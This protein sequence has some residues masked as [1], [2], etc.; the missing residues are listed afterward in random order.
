MLDRT[1]SLRILFCFFFIALSG[2]GVFSE[3]VKQPE[4]SDHLQRPLPEDQNHNGLPSELPTT[5]P[6]NAIEITVINPY[7]TAALGAEV[8]GVIENYYFEPGDLV[9]KGQVI[10]EISRKR[11][12]LAARK[13]EERLKA[14]GTALV[15]AEKDREIKEQLLSMEAG[16]LQELSRA[17]AEVEI[18][19]SKKAESQI[20]FDQAMLEL[21]AC[22]VKAPFTG[23]LA[24]RYKEAN[25]PVAPLEKLVL[26][27]DNAHVY[28]VANVPVSL[29]HLFKKHMKASFKHPSGKEF[30][31]TVER[32]EPIIDPKTDTR[33]IFGTDRQPVAGT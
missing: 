5:T 12:D 2:E 10:L 25:E 20:E 7:R 15:R 9:E 6:S 33:K 14:I 24:A 1:R 27:I 3:D 13:V 18:L 21:N 17:E 28:A 19:Q 8:G 4:I 29:A 32:I 11:Y 22:Q 26:M 23:Y 16:S 31:G 30:S